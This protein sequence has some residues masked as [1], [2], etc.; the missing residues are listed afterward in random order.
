MAAAGREVRDCEYTI[1]FDDG[2]SRE[3]FGNAVP[4]LDE[5]GKV[6]G[7]VG[8]FIDI[9]ERKRAEE[10]I[11]RRNALLDGIN[12]IFQQTIQCE[13]DEELAQ[14]CLRVAEKITGSKCG[15][16]G[17]I[18]ADGLPRDIAISDPGWELCTMYD[19]TGH[20][21][22]P[23][24]FK[25]HG[26]YGR[27]L[28]DGKSLL[29]NAPAEHPDSAG[30]PVDHPVLTAFLGVP[31]LDGDRTIGMIAV[32]NREGGYR[33]AD[34][35]SL[36]GLAPSVVGA[37]RRFRAERALRESEDR[38][39]MALDSA[40][41]GTFD[42]NPVTGDLVWDAQM[43]RIWGLPPDDKPD[44]IRMLERINAEDR[45][46]VSQIVAASVAPNA[47]G[48]YEAEY[49]IIWPD[50]TTHWSSARGRVYFQRE[51][52]R[53]LAVRM[54]GVQRDIT[55]RKRTEEQLQATAE[56]LKAI[57]ERAPVGI[58]TNDRECYLIEPNAAYQ[59]ICGYSAEELRGKKFTD[60]THPEDMAKTLLSYEQL[61]SNK[62]QSYEMEKRYIRKDGKIIWVRVIASKLNDDNNIGIIEDITERKQAE[63]QLR[64]TADRLQ[65]VLDNAPVGIVTGNRQNRF[66]ETNAAFQ[67]MTGFSGEELK[68][69]SWKAFTHPDDVADNEDLVDGL[70]QGK[71]KRYD[72]EKRYS[73]K[74]GRTIWVRVVSSRL[75][76]EHKISIIEDI[77]E[78]KRAA[79]QLRKS[80]ARSQRLIDSNIVGVIIADP[81]GAILDTNRAFLEM[82]GYARKDF[83]NGLGWRDLTPPEYSALDEASVKQAGEAGAFPPYE[84]ELLRKNGTRIPVIVGG[85]TTENRE[86]IVF[87]LDLTQ[88]KKA[89]LE[90]EQLARIVESADD[91]IV[92]LSLTGDILSWNEGAERLLGY[93]KREMIGASE[94][95]LLPADSG[96]EGEQ[97][98]EVIAGGKALDYFQTVRIAKSGEEKPVWLRIS[99]IREGGG[100]IIG[101]SKI[102]RDRS[103]AIQA[104]ALEEQ[105]RQ[106]QKIESLG[107]P[108][109]RRGA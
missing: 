28:Q 35:E 1:A 53:R 58:V 36:E 24:N 8:A 57:L 92:S 77:T 23:G 55:R 102:A 25:I 94:E 37:L 97:V 108:D 5:R 52:E 2:S 9:T 26:L 71:V 4:L 63:Q 60:H 96:Q 42:F 50:G 88:L 79:E 107:P 47:N 49:R 20:R 46:R 103:Q 48:N 74:D 105:L 29:T 75:D 10:E 82:V 59:S 99:P 89:Q 54:V 93:T 78:R 11:Y 100:K 69:M 6:R 76:D 19:K 15:F 33:Q 68:Q 34:R 64:A 31:L 18:G 41:F 40:Q 106:A 17:E 30:T 12:T 16:I 85:A 109:R 87:F 70:M 86:A 32:A 7:A 84:K 61:G 44:Y 43:K 3:I 38:L 95:I 51:G 90:L 39:R 66:V 27:V 45:E 83:E 98:R 101:I 21:R 81:D 62:L 80:E 72:F 13:T 104:H 56:R 65:A 73:F 91:A 14:T 67:R 22:P